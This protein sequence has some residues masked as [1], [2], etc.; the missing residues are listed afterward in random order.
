[1]NRLASFLAE[2]FIAADASSAAK[3]LESLA[4]HEILLV[5]GSQKA[6]VLVACFNKMDAAKAAAVLRRLPL[7]QAC[8]VLTHLE[9][10]QSARIWKEFSAPY[11]ERLKGVLEAPFVQLIS[12]VEK[13]P[14]GAV[15]RK[16]QTDFV[17]VRTETKVSALV[18]QLK[19]LPRK[20]IPQLCFVTSKNG[21]LK[22][23]IRTA[24]LAFYGG[25]SVCGSVMSR[26]EAACVADPIEKIRARMEQAELAALPVVN[27]QQIL[28][29]FVEKADLFTDEKTSF[30]QRFTK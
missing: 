8:Y 1:M 11:Q 2:K 28:L 26:C 5:I 23:I 21:E 17:S 14:I 13:Y 19:N 10:D 3:A 9:V 22:G 29:G 6:S 24:E 30:W 27:E 15:A 12:G 16:M 4:T 20:K 7:K 18:E 25:E